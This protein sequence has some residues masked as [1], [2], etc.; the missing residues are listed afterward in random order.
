MLFRNEMIISFLQSC[1]TK[2][3]QKNNS[4]RK[5]EVL[6]VLRNAPNQPGETNHVQVFIHPENKNWI[7]KFIFT[8][9][10]VYIC[11]EEISIKQLLLQVRSVNTMTMDLLYLSIFFFRTEEKR[12]A[13][14]IANYQNF[15]MIPVE[16]KHWQRLWI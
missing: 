8:N 9:M 11:V 16:K 7:I 12:E 2:G 13:G 3:I 10:H 5:N 14:T 4:L 15:P 1:C 6:G